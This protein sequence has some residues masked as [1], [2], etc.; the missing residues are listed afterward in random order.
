MNN[1]AEANQAY[2]A[3]QEGLYLAR[4]TLER[5][6]RHHLE[7]LIGGD[8]WRE[9][10]SGFTDINAF[11]DSLRLDKFRAIAGERQAIVRR[12]KELQPDVSNRQIARTLGVD[13]QT[14]NN[15]LTGENSPRPKQNNEANQEGTGE[16]SPAAGGPNSQFRTDFNGN[17]EWYTPAPYIELAR[18]VM[19]GIDLDPASCEHAQKTVQATRFYT[20]ADDGL[21]K[22]WNGRV[23]LN[24]PYAQPAIEQFIGKLVHEVEERLAAAILL[25]NNSTD[26]G[27]FHQAAGASSAICFTKGRIRFETAEGLT[28]Q[29]PAMGQ[30]FFYFGAEY[31][32]FAREFS[33]VGLVVEAV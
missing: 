11:M 33:S 23:W 16:N 32:K 9:C 8:A 27:W 1:G 26:T 6:F 18:R 14:V 19:G 7:P 12:I 22:P 28:P 4:F 30:A 29:S 15:D 17:N 5:A 24:P 10:G 25:T 21:S 13:H 20:E 2:G 31:Q 3:L